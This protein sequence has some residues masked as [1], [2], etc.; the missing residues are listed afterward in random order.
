MSD[1]STTR[2]SFVLGGLE[3]DMAPYRKTKSRSKN[4]WAFLDAIYV[5]NAREKRIVSTN[6]RKLIEAFLRS[7]DNALAMCSKSSMPM[8]LAEAHLNLG[9]CT[10]VPRDQR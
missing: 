9:K 8:R 3:E 2:T 5:L 1:V 7:V 4:D 6:N 10:M